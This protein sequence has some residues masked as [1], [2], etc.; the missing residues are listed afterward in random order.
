MGSSKTFQYT[1][2]TNERALVGKAVGHSA[3]VQILRYLSKN[4]LINNEIAMRITSLSD[5]TVSHHLRELKYA[6]L[7]NEEWIINQHYFVL[8]KDAKRRVANLR[9]IFV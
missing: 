7:I 2:I 4:V 8:A 1:K 3:R 6:G 5:G 9:Q